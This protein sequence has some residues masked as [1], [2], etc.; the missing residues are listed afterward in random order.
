MFIL[1]LVKFTLLIA[2]I[3]ISIHYP[4][5]T[6]PVPAVI[7]ASLYPPD[8]ALSVPVSPAPIAIVNVSG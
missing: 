7:V 1:L 2:I 6:F 4:Q 5:I 3:Q 8:A